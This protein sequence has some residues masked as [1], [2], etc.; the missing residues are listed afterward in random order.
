MAGGAALWF[1][2]PSFSVGH[3]APAAAAPAAPPSVTAQTTTATPAARCHASLV[4]NDAAPNAEILVRVGQAPVDVDRMPVGARL[5]FVATAEVRAKARRRPGLDATW[6]TGP[7]GRPRY[8]SRLQLDLSRARTGA[9]DP[10]P[11]G[12]PAAEL[13]ERRALPAR[14]TS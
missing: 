1:L 5:E 2:G 10:W 8:E 4:V 13:A 3:R 6:D 9:V 7:D 12:G 14:C 11:A